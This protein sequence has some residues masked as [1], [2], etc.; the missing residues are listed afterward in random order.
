MI[1]EN[2]FQPRKFSP[3]VIVLLRRTTQD[4]ISWLPLAM[5]QNQPFRH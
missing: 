3:T 5:K 4:G 1:F 2:P